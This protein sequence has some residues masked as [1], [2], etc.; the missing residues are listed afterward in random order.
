MKSLELDARRFDVDWLRIIAFAFLIFYHIGMY[1]VADWGWHIKSEHQ[2]HALQNLMLLINPWRMSLIFLISGIALS[3]AEPRI[4]RI[5][6]LKVRF[7]RVLTP[8][9]IG[10]FIIVPPQLYFELIATEGFTGNYWA[11]YDFYVDIDTDMYPSHQYGPLGL[12]T[13]NH[14]WYLAYLWAYTLVYLVISPILSRIPWPTLLD[15]APVIAIFL[16]LIVALIIYDIT[17]KVHYPRTYALYNDWYSHALYFTFFLFG[18]I[19]AKAQDL[20]LLIIHKRRLWACI[21]VTHYGLLLMLHHDIAELWLRENGYSYIESL[22][23]AQLI[24][25]W[26][27]CANTVA[28]LFAILGYGGAYLNKGHALLRYVNEAILPWYIMHQTVIIILAVA[29][30]SLHLGGFWE[31]LLLTILTFLLCGL[32]YEG[33]KRW[34]VTRFLFGMKI[35][36]E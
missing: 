22:Q 26:V 20:W 16:A 34:H 23:A 32:I 27:L 1:Y 2:S 18:Y 19:L 21:A 13:W 6:L 33:I 24:L 28:W 7:F 25:K 14:L 15:R 31:P 5:R 3:L 4:T 36:P 8:V 35:K 30:S 10:M 17:L 11:F 12:L 29:L 9:V